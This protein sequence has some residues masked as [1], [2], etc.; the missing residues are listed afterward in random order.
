MEVFNHHTQVI[1]LLEKH[2]HGHPITGIEIGTQGAGLTKAIL[3]FCPNVTKLYTVDP[4]N[5]REGNLF[6]AGHPQEE[7]NTVKEW[8]YTALAEFGDRVSI[9]PMTSDQA[10]EEIDYSVDF[11]WIDGDHTIEAVKRDILHGLQFV[12]TEGILGGHDHNTVLEAI[13]NTLA[14]R[15]I[16]Q[17]EDQTWW[18]FL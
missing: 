7:H 5:H 2:F 9:M 6:E 13:Q 17:G 18:C 10:F 8:A 4:W 3:L 11:V 1:D 12:K 14:G 15:E 16:H